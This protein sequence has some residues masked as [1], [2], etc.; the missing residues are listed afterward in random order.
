MRSAAHRFAAARLG[1]YRD[2]ELAVDQ[3]DRV[4]AHVRGCSRCRGALAG[5]AECGREL[6]SLRTEPPDGLADRIIA[7]LEADTGET[8]QS[9]VGAAEIAPSRRPAAGLAT[10]W[11]EQR[12]HLRVTLPIALVAGLA[13][14]AVEDLGTLTG[15]DVDIA[16]AC[17]VCGSNVLVPLALLHLGWLLAARALRLIGALPSAARRRPTQGAGRAQMPVM[18][19][20]P[21]SPSNRWASMFSPAPSS[22]PPAFTLAACGSASPPHAVASNGPADAVS[23]PTRTRP[24][25]PAR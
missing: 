6:R 23:T 25:R 17:A 14:T 13:I 12:A 2:G 15:G 24:E 18:K 20:R 9:L 3:R 10:S 11:R 8:R 21:R 7:R 5:L 4:E 1:A 16:A 22:W 19:S